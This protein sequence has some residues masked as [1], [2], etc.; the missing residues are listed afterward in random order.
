MINTNRKRKLKMSRWKSYTFK[1]K[2]LPDL[3]VKLDEWQKR[4]LDLKIQ[5]VLEEDPERKEMLR[6]KRRSATGMINFYKYSIKKM[7][8]E[9]K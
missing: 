5:I 9:I 7:K 8:E 4:Y 6:K 1:R 2:K 3:E